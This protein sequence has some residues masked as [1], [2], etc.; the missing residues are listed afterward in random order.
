MSISEEDEM[1][2]RSM[3]MSEEDEMRSMSMSMSEEDEMKSMSMSISEDEMKS[4]SMSISEDE[5]RSRSMS[6]SEE[7]EM[8][9]MSISEE[10]EM[11]PKLSSKLPRVY[12]RVLQALVYG[13]GVKPAFV[14]GS[15]SNDRYTMRLQGPWRS[16]VD[17]CLTEA[18]TVRSSALYP[19]VVDL[20]GTEAWSDVLLK[21]QCAKD[22]DP[23]EDECHAVVTT[24]CPEISPRFLFGM[25]IAGV[26]ISFMEWLDDCASLY[27]LHKAKSPLLDV[28]MYMGV[29]DAVAKMWLTAG[30]LHCDLHPNNILIGRKTHAVYIIDYGMAMQIDGEMRDDL[31]EVLHR[32]G[33]RAEDAFDAICKDHALKVIVRRGYNVDDM[34]DWNDD[35]TFLRLLRST[36]CKVKKKK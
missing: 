23:D 6:M 34:D 11:T 35:G 14:Y 30:V 16:I 1:R 7:D 8:M 12:V 31:H 21:M 4:M 5:M 17:R 2:S 25:T 28:G 20:G 29:R 19:R 18:S 27:D 3:S 24:A 10:E 22:A 33:V 32:K 13:S 36:Y 9:S 26:R 15:R